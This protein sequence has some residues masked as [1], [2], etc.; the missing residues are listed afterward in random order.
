MNMHRKSLHPPAKFLNVTRR[1]E[2]L[3]ELMIGYIVPRWKVQDVVGSCKVVEIEDKTEIQIGP[4]IRRHPPPVYPE[5]SDLEC[6]AAD[7]QL[8]VLG[9]LL[10]TLNEA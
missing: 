6:V 9:A 4:P 5:C 3:R 7:A 8:T 1:C 2:V 10:W